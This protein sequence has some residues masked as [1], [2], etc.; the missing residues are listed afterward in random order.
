MADKMMRIA[1][2]GT[3]GTAKAIKLN[4]DGTLYRGSE[5]E[6][7]FEG[8]INPIDGYS[9][10][11]EVKYKGESE[12]WIHVSIDQPDWSL[13]MLPPSWAS[14]GYAE[15]GFWP[16]RRDSPGVWTDRFP[17]RSLAIYRYGPQDLEEDYLNPTN[18]LE[19]K[20]LAVREDFQYQVN[21]FSDVEANA[22]VSVYRIWR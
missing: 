2:R 1:G 3:D 9:S 17:A 15:R 12:T 11:M 20:A 8:T 22:K 4:N 7:L 18:I 16:E 10:P 5:H 19:A 14:G 13:V 21:N 6:V